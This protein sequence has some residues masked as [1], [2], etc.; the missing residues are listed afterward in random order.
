LFL[1]AAALPAG[2]ARKQKSIADTPVHEQLLLLLD[3]CARKHLELA[4]AA[5]SVTVMRREIAAERADHAAEL[6]AL[7][8]A[9]AALRDAYKTAK[10]AGAATISFEGVPY[11][12]KRFREFTGQKITRR[13]NLAARLD[14]HA[15]QGETYD[16]S[17]QVITI[18]ISELDS[19]EAEARSNI[20]DIMRGRQ[21]AGIKGLLDD[22]R[23]VDVAS[24][25]KAIGRLETPNKIIADAAD[26]ADAAVA[27][28]A[29][30]AGVVAEVDAFLNPSPGL[31]Q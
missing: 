3:D 10:A 18:R 1:L 23:N 29:P 13:K 7:D 8:A 15:R 5:V 16:D 17:L 25:T 11:S 2:C 12:E 24:I 31:S 20:H 14:R 27:A 4:E 21:V 19:R 22:M 28:G 26:A 6:A 30:D 9:L